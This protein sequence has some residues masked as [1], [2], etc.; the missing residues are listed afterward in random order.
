[1]AFVSALA[2]MVAT[3]AA[4]AQDQP[5]PV[6]PKLTAAQQTEVMRFGDDFKR[7]I[8]AAKNETAFV[9]EASR[10]IE[11]AGFKPWPAS[12][13]KADAVPG[14]RWYAVNRGRSIA[15]FVIGSEPTAS[16][17]RIV[18][19]HN[20][21]VRIE[22]KP[23]PFRDSFDI[24]ML[25]TRTHGSLKNYQWV[26]R[27]LALIGR[28][29]KMDGTSVEIDIGHQPGDAVLMITDLAPHVD[30]D[31]RDRRN[32][33]VIQTEELDP[34]LA[35]TRD[36]AL[37]A[38]KA[39]YGLVPEDFLSA[40]L[41]IVPAQMPVDVGLDH[42]LVGAYGHDDR[43]NGFAA[44]RAIT[45]VRTPQKTAVAYGVNNEEVGSWT[46]GVE[47]QWFSTLVAEIIAAQEPAYNDLMLRHALGASQALV[48]DCTTALDPGFPQPYLP[49]SSARLGWGLVFKEY[50]AGR[51]AD[52]EFFAHVRRVMSD[53]G[54]HWQVHAYRAGYGGGTIA[55]WFANANI[56]AID[57]GIG[58]LSMHSPM[59]VSA[60]VDLW[61]LYRGF[62]AFWGVTTPRTGAPSA[63]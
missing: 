43:S 37:K 16:G 2:S 57:V 51:E 41:Q 50:G 7:F 10:M 40:D 14:S 18:N 55:Q 13:R 44:F 31:F 46:T 25:D 8:G 12:A 47:S 28:V 38:L 59:D 3:S 61:E 56:D 24:S 19:T 39:K 4:F 49:N 45:E 23:R 9:R 48:S 5:G 52:A 22:L 60:K 15:A 21:S 58:I 29:T 33:D 6:W 42:Q 63:R 17:L 30:N 62:K 11:A 32:R 34:I 35:L 27:P 53:A 26:N 20:D 54:V 1:V 36:A